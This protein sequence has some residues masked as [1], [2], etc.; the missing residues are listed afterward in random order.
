MKKS[1]S[2]LILSLS[3][4]SCEKSQKHICHCTH[5]SIGMFGGECVNTT[6]LT[7]QQPKR[8]ATQ[9]CKDMSGGDMW[10]NIECNL[11]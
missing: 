6:T 10:Y 4:A 3:M 9:E 7:I 8:K 11:K 5:R 1:F 2:L